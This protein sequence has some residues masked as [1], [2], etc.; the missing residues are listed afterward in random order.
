MY[1]EICD[2]CEKVI[3]NK[4]NFDLKFVVKEFDERFDI[5]RLLTDKEQQLIIRDAALKIKKEP[6]RSL[7]LISKRHRPCEKWK[8]TIP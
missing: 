8:Q 6:N 1:P 3:K 7:K 5:P 4:F 2:D